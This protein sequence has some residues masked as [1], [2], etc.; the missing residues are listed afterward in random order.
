MNSNDYNIIL[1]NIDGF[2]KDKID[3]CSHLKNIK[4]NSYYFSEMNTVAPYTFASLHAIFS[5]LYPSSN[6]VNSYY[7]MFKFKKNSS[8]FFF[9][10]IC[11]NLI[12]IFIYII[13]LIIYS[14]Y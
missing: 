9:N 4:E 11:I 14:T 1:I 6:G 3:L 8:G 10:S 13:S 7:N 2:R 5:G 12:K